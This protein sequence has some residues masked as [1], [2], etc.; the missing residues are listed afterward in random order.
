L[1]AACFL[2]HPDKSD[3]LQ[4][5]LLCVRHAHQVLADRVELNLSHGENAGQNDKDNH[6][7]SRNCHMNH[8][9]HLPAV[10]KGVMAQ[11]AM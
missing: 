4:F 10:C 3:G 2:G 8:V 11:L 9:G 5:N 6:T 7:E 1:N